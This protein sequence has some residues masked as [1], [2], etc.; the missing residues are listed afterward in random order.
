MVVV[1]WRR[2]RQRGRGLCGREEEDGVEGEGETC[3]C[4]RAGNYTELLTSIN[5]VRRHAHQRGSRWA[6]VMTK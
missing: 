3:F 6:A 5:I 1:V 4:C 2:E